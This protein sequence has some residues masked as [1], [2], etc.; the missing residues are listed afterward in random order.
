M[1]L[2]KQLLLLSYFCMASISASMITPALPRIAHQF[3]LTG[4][5]LEWIVSLF[6]VGYVFGQLIYA[7]IAN[8]FGRLFALRLGLLVNFV[9]IVLCLVAASVGSYDLLLLGRLISA[10]GAAAGLSCAFMLINELLTP[11]GAKR[12]ISFSIVLFTL[13]VAFSVLIGGYMTQQFGWRNCFWVLLCHDVLMLLLTWLFK[14]TLQQ[15]ATI[16]VS[17]I[18]KSYWAALKSKQLVVG[19]LVIG[20]CSFLTYGYLAAAPLYAETVLGLS[21]SHYG[22]WNLL[23]MAGMLSSGFLGVYLMKRYAAKQVILI[24]LVMM[25]PCLLLLGVLVF[26]QTKI[27]VLFFIVTSLLYLFGALLFPSATFIA[28]NALDDKAT[29]SSMMSF[30]N[31]GSV[32]I[33][34]IVMGYIPTMR[35]EAFLLNGVSSKP[36]QWNLWQI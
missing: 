15:R 36:R 35:I 21:P 23:N 33:T 5:E 4:A 22:D 17:S 2:S 1:K 16:Q 12:C 29:A 6:L 25:A 7:P 24:G 31:M 20:V 11:A 18:V 10:L 28:S 26:V 8:R 9:G 13:G 3:Q 14:E 27:T 34:V 30:I 19:S 32:M